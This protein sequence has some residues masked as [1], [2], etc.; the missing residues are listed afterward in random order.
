MYASRSGVG[1]DVG[2]VRPSVHGWCGWIGAAFG[3]RAPAAGVSTGGG[4]L[5]RLRG[6]GEL[7]CRVLGDAEVFGDGTGGEAEL[8]LAA[9][10]GGDVDHAGLD[11]LG[12]VGDAHVEPRAA[13]L[14]PLQELC[15]GEEQGGFGVQLRGGEG[16]LHESSFHLLRKV[17]PANVEPAGTKKVTWG[18][19]C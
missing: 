19:W 4:G 15:P 2:T 18:R 13:D 6:G 5:C 8:A 7:W 11:E 12:V 1:D 16:L 9:A 10:R 3:P 17:L 14:E